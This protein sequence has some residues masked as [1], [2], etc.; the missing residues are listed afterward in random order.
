MRKR[1]DHDKQDENGE[2]VLPNGDLHAF[3]IRF[4]CR[5]FPV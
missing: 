5:R 3:L 4:Q 1:N 2:G